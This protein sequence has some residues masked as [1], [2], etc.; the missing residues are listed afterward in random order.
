MDLHVAIVL[1]SIPR[2]PQDS[3]PS[4]GHPLHNFQ[5]WEYNGS[6]SMIRLCFMVQSIL[7]QRDYL[8]RPDLL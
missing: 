3:P 7:R 6:T 1:G 4:G 8:S 2:W 5:D